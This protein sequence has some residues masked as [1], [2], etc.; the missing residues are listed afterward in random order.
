MLFRSLGIAAEDESVARHVASNIEMTVLTD[1]AIINTDVTNMRIVIVPDAHKMDK[2]GLTLDEVYDKLSKIR[3][4]RGL[5]EK[6]DF[7][8]TI[9][10]DVQSF[11]KIQTMYDAIKNAK[12]KGIDGIERAVI[13]IV[14]YGLNAVWV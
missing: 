3:A 5:V 9:T 14:E 11:K 4:V 10:S 6:E 13:S 8:L 1:V 7:N 12:I 2:R